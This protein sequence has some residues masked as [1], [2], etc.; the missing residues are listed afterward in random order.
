MTR[1]IALSLALFALCACGD[2]A[3]VVDTDP[4]EGRFCSLSCEPVTD[5]AFFA[6]ELPTFVTRYSTTEPV[7]CRYET[8]GVRCLYVEDLT[9]DECAALAISEHRGCEPRVVS[10][11]GSYAVTQLVEAIPAVCE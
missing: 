10:P 2:V 5:A 9:C 8:A 7:E 1:L 3:D 6:G 11:D 4:R